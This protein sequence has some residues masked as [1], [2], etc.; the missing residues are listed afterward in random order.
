MKIFISLSQ[1]VPQNQFDLAQ[2]VFVS[3]SHVY[4]KAFFI[5]KT[6]TKT[7]TEKETAF[8]GSLREFRGTVDNAV[9]VL[10]VNW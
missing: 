4:V 2:T 8:S 3:T 5:K 9:Q 10:N 1:Q 6:K 7:K